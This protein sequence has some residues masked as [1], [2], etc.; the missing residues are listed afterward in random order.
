MSKPNQFNQFSSHFVFKLN[1][2]QCLLFVQG[3]DSGMKTQSSV[4]VE[5]MQQAKSP[6]S[7]F[8]YSNL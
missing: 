6:F 4:L 8:F 3:M 7:V 2:V 1:V 5:N